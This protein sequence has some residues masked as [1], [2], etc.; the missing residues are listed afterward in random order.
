MKNSIRIFYTSFM[1]LVM[2]AVV[3]SFILRPT[4]IEPPAH[5]SFPYKKAKLTERQAAAHLL[6]RFTFGARP[7]DVDR[8]TDMGLEKWFLQQLDAKLPNDTLDQLLSSYDALKLSN[9]E[10]ANI[11][12]KGGALLRMAV[13]DG[14]IDKDSV[15]KADQKEYRAQLQRYMEEKGLK[16]QQELFRQLFNQK[17]LRATYSENQL[18]EVLTD[19]WFNHFNVSLTKNDCAQFVPAYERDVIRPH[20]FDDFEK[21]LTGTAKSPAM[22]YYLDNF[23]SV[24]EDI[25][26]ANPRA[27]R[28]QQLM[29]QRMKEM[30]SDTSAAAMALKK[31]QQQRKTRG[32]NENYARE[33]MELHTLGVDGGYT[34]QDV[35][36]AA[37][38]L[39]GW[40]VYPMNDFYSN[41]ARKNLEKLGEEKMQ[42]QGYVREGDFLFAAN[43]HDKSA[44]TVL[45]KQ[46]NANGGYEEG[47][48]LLHLLAH[49]PSTAKFICKKLAVR[50]VNDNPPA[51]LIDKMSKTFLAKDGNIREVLMT[52]VTSPEF[53]SKEALR[54]KTKSP[55]EL[56]ISSVR[57][58]NATI[59][60]PYQLYV[61]INKMGQRMYYYQAPTGFP[62]NGKYWINTG[63]LL[64]RM[65]FGLALA[66]NR[67]PGIT[68]DLAALNN[69]HE[70]ESAEAALETYG[71][72]IMPER[73]LEASIKRLTPLLNDPELGKKVDEA[74]GKTAAPQEANMMQANEQTDVMDEAA[75]LMPKK[76]GGKKNLN[77]I[78]KNPGKNNYAALQMAKGNNTMLSQVVGI[79]IGSPEFQR[80]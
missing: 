71:K 79:I 6:N 31:Q 43:R 4:D 40:T 78:P 42:K 22:L 7:G 51:S 16:Q 9:E 55:F 8:V 28:N 58:L 5:V 60:Q 19:F 12:P 50:F 48:E 34:Q 66:S 52:M 53:W 18:Q 35:T 29:E 2:G 39:T 65:N 15:N 30:E 46:F 63:S 77:K 62:D 45:G 25:A 76:K 74:A 24:G 75:A 23:T 33:V 38:V 10:I 36:Q 73:D 11:Y 47:V 13:R 56:A 70:P 14:Y 59:N 49:H 44:K 64:N 61:W 21:L 57:N 72:M 32:L 26:P 27:A 17:I 69:H 68:V 1:A 67:I 20:V 3:C 54:E 80:K 41:A 37:K